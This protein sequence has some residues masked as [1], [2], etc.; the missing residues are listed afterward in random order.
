MSMDPA[1]KQRLADELAKRVPG[2]SKKPVPDYTIDQLREHDKKEDAW[3]AVDGRIYD[4]TDWA[5]RH[6]GGSLTIIGVA[7]RDATDHFHA[8]HPTEV[9]PTLAPFHVGNLV[10][11]EPDEVTVAARKMR[12]DIWMLG[13]HET[14]YW[15]YVGKTFWSGSL[16][17]SAIYLI[18]QFGEM[19]A[20][21]M[22]GGLLLGLYWQQTAFVG[23]DSGHNAITHNKFK[24]TMLGFVV[25]NLTTGISIAWWKRSHN[26]HHCLTNSVEYDPD[27]QH[28]PVFAVTK[29]LFNSL[30]STYHE[31]I[32]HFDAP[33]RFLVQYQHILFYPIMMLARFNLYAQSWILLL[34]YR[35]RVEWRHAEMMCSVI[36]LFWMKYVMSFCQTWGTWWAVLLISH[37]FTALLHVQIT[38]SHFCMETYH[39]VKYIEKSEDF[40]RVQ[41]ETSLDVDCYEIFD[42]FHGGLQFQVEHH[43]FP[44]VSRHNLRKV[45]TMLKEFCDKYGLTHHEDTFVGGNLRTLAALKQASEDAK[46]F[47]DPKKTDDGAKTDA[48]PPMIWDGLNANG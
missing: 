12:D 10:D 39:G 46:H 29:K 14:N 9:F 17:A 48:I 23:H 13:Y 2:T 31:R 21:Q 6:P 24:D 8:F 7:G 5:S 38:L 3:I 37:A 18:T 16:L 25:G 40:I 47:K 45:R 44:K 41:L 11:Y 33:S 34:D 19:P 28:L 1:R 32:M 20:M 26:V 27:I 15:Y 35:K 42:W 22:L 36:Y 4:V 43:L 30:Y